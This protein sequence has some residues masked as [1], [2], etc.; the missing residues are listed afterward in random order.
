MRKQVL[1]FVVATVF[2]L[3][4]TGVLQAK[5]LL[6][7]L[8]STSATGTTTSSGVV[9]IRVKFRS[10]RKAIIGTF[11]NISVAKS[12]DYI[13]TYKTNGVE[14]A[15]VGSVSPTSPNPQ[16]RELLFGTCSSRVCRYDGNI[17][18]AKF[19]VTSVLKTG[20]KIVKTFKLRV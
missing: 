19:V 11:T 12:I 6:P 1:V 10:D 14:Q 13:L 8:K 15:A 20:K 16:I 2:F 7:Q 4:L 17:T 18:D 3:T 5:R 9:N